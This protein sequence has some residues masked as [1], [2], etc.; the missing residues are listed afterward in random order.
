MSAIKKAAVNIYKTHEIRCKTT[1]H[2]GVGAMTKFN[3]IYADLKK[4]GLEKVIV[5]A[6]QS[7]YV[8]CG[9]W[10]LMEPAF[11]NNQIEYTIYNS[12]TPNPGNVQM[13]EASTV[14][15]SF[16]AKIVISVDWPEFDGS[17]INKERLLL[18]DS[19]KQLT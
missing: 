2:L 8:K 10:D 16:G 15:R 17:L 18:G 9:A 5:A 4:R 13:D 6:R 11:K 12:I 19:A 7:A 14:A 3:D 1:F